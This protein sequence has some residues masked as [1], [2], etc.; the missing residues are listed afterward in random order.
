MDG[1]CLA[2]CEL[3][4]REGSC[5]KLIESHRDGDRIGSFFELGL[6]KGEDGSEEQDERGSNGRLHR[7]AACICL[8]YGER[9]VS[10]CCV[11]FASC[12]IFC[13]SVFSQNK[14]TALY[15]NEKAQWNMPTNRSNK[16]NCPRHVDPPSHGWNI[17]AFRIQTTSNLTRYIRIQHRST[18]VRNRRRRSV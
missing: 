5:G 2:G 16:H 3:T 6:R 12:S 10:I 11:C 1:A 15:M 14:A 7:A 8:R 18:C 4:A 17:N 9:M 13:F